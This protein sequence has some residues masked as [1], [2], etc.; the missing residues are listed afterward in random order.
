[1]K[2]KNAEGVEGFFLY[3][4]FKKDYFFRVYDEED[5]T[6]YID[7]KILAEEVKVKV[8]GNYLSLHED[9][10]GNRLDYASK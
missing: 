8:I 3:H 2:E 9:E 4:P 5:K 6:K 7:Y 10:S 1:M